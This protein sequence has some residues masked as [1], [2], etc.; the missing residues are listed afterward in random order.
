MRRSLVLA[1]SAWIGLFVAAQAFG[2][3]SRDFC[4]T[5]PESPLCGGVVEPPVDPDPCELDP[6]SC[7]PPPTGPCAANPLLCEPPVDAEIDPEPAAP[8]VEMAGSGRFKGP[9]FNLP[10]EATAALS[11]DDATFSLLSNLDCDPATG[12]VVVKGRQGRK[13]QLFLDGPSLDAYADSI[14]F[15]A[16]LTAGRGGAVVAKSAKIVLQDRA[17]GSQSLRIKMQ[18]VIEELG[19]VVYKANLTTLDPAATPETARVLCH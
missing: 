2:L 8:S 5:H 4:E 15:S 7:E 9:G 14:A 12:A 13:R 6:A 19:E 11:Y 17:D 10:T 16:R 1:G 3:P 18:V